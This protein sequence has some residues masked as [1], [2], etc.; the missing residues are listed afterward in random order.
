MLASGVGFGLLGVLGKQA[1][2]AG[3]T[4]GE[5][6]SLR[7]VLASAMLWTFLLA[8]R[9]PRLGI[10]WRLTGICALLGIVGYAVFS[11]FYFMAL[12]GL[13]ASLTVLLLYTYPVVVTVAAWI[14]FKERLAGL[15][16]LALPLGLVGLVLLVFMDVSVTSYAALAF[17]LGASVFYSVYILISR[18]LL[19]GVSP[20]VSVVLIQSAAALV[21]S[22][23]HLT[24]GAR[25]AEIVS[26][27]W[28]TLLAVALLCTVLPMAL[29]LS[30]LKKLKSSEASML[31]MAEPITSIVVAA[32]VLG[33]RLAPLQ[34][35]GGGAVLA[36]M[37]LVARGE[38]TP[39]A[40]PQ[41]SAAVCKRA[42]AG[43]PGT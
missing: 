41:E 38:K 18:R 9:G 15:Q 39:A 32:I 40:S 24:D 34:L 1:Y 11:S 16:L 12:A 13:S 21:L 23:L 33:E 37:V 14:M 25:V 43:G 10:T 36:A 7:F 42:S 30:G 6:L 3:L 4:P 8:T 35:L 20:L 2:Q 17:G 26:S 31:S 22:A 28:P 5:L 27:T 19:H 29:F